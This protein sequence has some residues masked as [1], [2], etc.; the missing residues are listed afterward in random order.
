MNPS[1]PSYQ[2]ATSR[3]VW[4]E[5]AHFLGRKDLM[6]ACLVCRQ[7]HRI[8]SSHFWGNVISHFK[9]DDHAAQ[10]SLMHLERMLPE[11]R[12]EV[13]RLMHTL[14]IPSNQVLPLEVS[15]SGWL[16]GFLKYLP[17]LQSLIVSNL[18]T[19]DHGSLMALGRRILPA[20]NSLKFLDASNCINTTAQGLSNALSN[21]PNL[22]YLDL[23]ASQ[24]VRGSNVLSQ[25]SY[26]SF[27]RVLK[28]SRCGLKDD[29]IKS[30]FFSSKLSSL[31]ISGNFL[32][33][34]G[35]EI[36]LDKLPE[37]PPAYK[38]M[39]YSSHDNSQ[40]RYAG[41]S[42]SM[43]VSHEGV[44]TF[45]VRRLT[46]DMN[47]YLQIEEGLPLNFNHFNLASNDLSINSLC[48]IYGFNHYLQH[49]DIG[50]LKLNRLSMQDN[51][52]F[53]YKEEPDVEL[54]DSEFFSATFEN[55]RSLRIH[56]SIITS[57]PFSQ[58]LINSQ[59][60]EK[61]AF[62]ILSDE[63]VESESVD[64]LQVK[65]KSTIASSIGKAY[66]KQPKIF[67]PLN[68]SPHQYNLVQDDTIESRHPGRFQP[69][70]LPNI[71]S[72]T[73]TGIPSHVCDI[74]IPDTINLFIR[75]C[76][77]DENEDY[78]PF[79]SLHQDRQVRF[80]SNTWRK[81]TLEILTLETYERGEFTIP[82]RTLKDLSPISS[83][84]NRENF[85]YYEGF[86][87]EEENGVSLNTSL[88][89]EFS[90]DVIY[91]I[92]EERKR[93]FNDHKLNAIFHPN[94]GP[95]IAT[96]SSS[97]IRAKSGYWKGEVRVKRYERNP[98]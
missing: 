64:D 66:Q 77:E 46:S 43:K 21:L 82:K 93:L 74:R 13:R 54:I 26:F 85:S 78:I 68:A 86:Y 67:Q 70:L 23:S 24:G 3:Q 72:L 20:N 71:R 4:S 44:E 39:R 87:S 59:Y 45:V 48:R 79:S 9:L 6:S 27:L 37:N 88:S 14:H 50:T 49:L 41:S 63:V 62:T 22:I 16:I 40:Y 2:E 76:G 95:Q 12:I 7:W 36:L 38:T 90:V 65:L 96:N 17:N 81:G 28:I 18:S 19:F 25:I 89:R 58:K 92:K 42:L 57:N 30:L 56:H 1:P 60:I 84:S 35:V 83:S 98:G 94:S 32:T 5:V 10:L 31:D 55:L 11:I 73:L 51:R 75:E 80:N 34:R 29:N 69:Q 91:N 8:F 61:A 47:A 53:K 33:E 97:P 15:R 52:V